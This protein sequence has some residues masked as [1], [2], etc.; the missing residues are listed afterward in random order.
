MQHLQYRMKFPLK[1]AVV[2]YL[3]PLKGCLRYIISHLLFL[4]STTPSPLLATP[5]ASDSAFALDCVHVMNANI[6]LYRIVLSCRPSHGI[7]V[8]AVVVLLTAADAWRQTR[9]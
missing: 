5:H 8:I 4:S 1:F 3:L 6:V 9:C 7:S 2:L